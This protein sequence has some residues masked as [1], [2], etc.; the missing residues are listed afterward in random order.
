LAYMSGNEGF[1]LVIGAIQ[2]T[3]ACGDRQSVSPH[4]TEDMTRAEAGK[5]DSCVGAISA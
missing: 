2:G 3:V 1:E 4:A 5:H